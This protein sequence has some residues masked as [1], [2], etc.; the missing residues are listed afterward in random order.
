MY[1]TNVNLSEHKLQFFHM[2]S[3]GVNYFYANCLSLWLTSARKVTLDGST[4]Y[5]F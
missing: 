3:I 5:E 1:E 2:A 4:K